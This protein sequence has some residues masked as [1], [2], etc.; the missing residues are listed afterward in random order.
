MPQQEPGIGLGEAFEDVGEVVGGAI[1]GIGDA[2]AGGA[3]G[4][5][6]PP[7][8]EGGSSG[9]EGGSSGGGGGG[10]G[11]QARAKA[12]KNN[13]RFFINTLKELGIPLTGNMN[14]LINNAIA[15]DYNTAS[16]MF[17]LRQ[18][19]EYHRRFTG[20]F[21]KNG[22]M[23]MSE[24][25]YLSNL[26]QYESIASK[27]HINLT[28]RMTDWMFRNNV[29]PSEFADRATAYTR[30]RRN[31]DLYRAFRAELIQAGE[32]P[33][34][35]T[36]KRMLRFVL[37][38]GN[39]QWYD[40]WQDAVTRNAAISAGI[41]VGRRNALEQLPQGLIERISGLGLSESA[42]NKGFEQL[43]DD[44]ANLLPDSQFFGSGI[45]RADLVTLRFGG[46]GR[47]EIKNR[48]EQVIAQRNLAGEE[49]AAPQ[50]VQTGPK[51]TSLSYGGLA[52]EAGE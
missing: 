13:R 31:P 18:T 34:Q 37:G 21:N 50:F 38:E 40:L 52:G 8:G 24:S 23:K 32:K 47:Q 35:I 4:F 28:P 36:R 10:G 43:A 39:R 2:P 49:K 17:Y 16:F 51:K 7:G 27:A 44:L 5:V 15:K 6:A 9:G 20:I 48:V 11:S 45:T 19:K 3:G 22:T 42:L 46:R 1:G 25:Q 33:A 29:S 41:S 12:N 26:R 30:L 14:Q